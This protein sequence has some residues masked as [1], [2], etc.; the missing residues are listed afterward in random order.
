MRCAVEIE[1]YLPARRQSVR[2]NLSIRQFCRIVNN[3]PKASQSW[4]S[5]LGALRLSTTYLTLPESPQDLRPS[6]VA[7]VIYY[8]LSSIIY[9]FI[10]DDPPLRDLSPAVTKYFPAHFA[11]PV[12]G[13]AGGC[14]R[15][16][17]LSCSCFAGRTRKTPAV[18]PFVS[19]SPRP[20]ALCFDIKD[21]CPSFCP[22]LRTLSS[23]CFL[24]L[25]LY[26]EYPHFLYSLS[27]N[28]LGP[29][30]S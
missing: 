28:H 26:V 27:L 6:A 10:S 14:P 11:S 4:H 29:L 25:P 13:G 30:P 5:A 24:Y 16:G 15:Y 19:G 21:C 8:H 20:L 17:Q 3:T 2:F 12:K 23:P 7:S 1:I 18:T 9:S 22:A